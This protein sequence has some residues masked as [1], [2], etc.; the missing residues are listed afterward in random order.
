MAILVH[1]QNTLKFCHT[2]LLSFYVK[3]CSCI[4]LYFDFIILLVLLL[5]LQLVLKLTATAVFC[6]TFTRASNHNIQ[7]HQI[8]FLSA[9][10][11]SLFICVCSTK[12]NV[13]SYT[14]TTIAVTRH[15]M[16][17]PTVS[18]FNSLNIIWLPAN[19]NKIGS[20]IIQNISNAV[21]T[22]FW[23]TFMIHFVRKEK[24]KQSS[25]TH[26]SLSVPPPLTPKSK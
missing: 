23:K 20:K 10:S 14:L 17:M 1:I 19:P 9:Q 5:L 3:H 12:S 24:R 11:N 25:K 15:A 16:P 4:N 18:R 6:S 2:E 26:W 21:A 22:G 13:L 8:I 7:N